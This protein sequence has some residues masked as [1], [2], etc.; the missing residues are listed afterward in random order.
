MDGGLDLVGNERLRAPGWRA[1]GSDGGEKAKPIVYQG[2]DTV[3]QFILE[4]KELEQQ[5]MKKYLATRMMGCFA[6][7]LLARR[8]TVR[9]ANT[10]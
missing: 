2:A 3:K 5:I 10:T 7:P 8:T 1:R 4:M 6:R 9:S